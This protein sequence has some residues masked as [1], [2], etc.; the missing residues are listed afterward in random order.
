MTAWRLV[1]DVGGTNAR[2]AR[3]TE[4]G[5]L[6][7]WRSYPVGRFA[8]FLCAVETYLE[9]TGGLM[10]CTSA[11]IGAAGPVACG[12]V[13]L[14]NA[15]W[16]I[17]ESEVSEALGVP[18]VLVN[19][20]E[21][22]GFSVPAMAV[23]D[24]AMVGG[25]QPNLTASNRFILANIGTGFGA[26]TLVKAGGEWISCPSEAGHMSLNLA[27]GFNQ[28]LRLKFTFVEQ[29]LSGRGLCNLYA[30]IT[31]SVPPHDAAE[32]VDRSNSDA[33][34]AFALQIFIEILGDV[35]GNLALTVA[36][37]DGVFLCGSVARGLANVAGLS[38]LRHA[39]EDKGRMREW[40]R[41]IPIAIIVREDAALAG[42]SV[43]P[44]A[45]PLR[46]TVG[47]PDISSARLPG[48]I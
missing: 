23:S 45:R 26:A 27:A 31:D 18:S 19:D 35:L 46:S 42:L 22:V 47:K 9:D 16:Y 25:L 38:Q 36:A 30:A 28:T 7:S 15:A 33:H 37:W 4:A 3:A 21:A 13:K 43:V 8:S 11:A 44:I 29:V 20:V 24:F 41:Q 17:S 39:F 6:L 1:S 5:S 10:G 14:T 48:I 40:M 2:F 32:I 34:S 12:A